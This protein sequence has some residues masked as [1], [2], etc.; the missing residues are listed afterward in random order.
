[1]TSL[2]EKMA[3][4]G[5]L[6][7]YGQVRT[8]NIS[9]RGVGGTDPDAIYNLCLILKFTLRKS[10][11]KYNITVCNCIYIHTN[12]TTCSVTQSLCPIL[13]FFKFLNLLFKI[14]MYCHQLI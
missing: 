4:L 9:L 2:F 10:C 7:G 5:K 12:I 8:Q 11:H 6:E 3:M 1:M 13:L 14:L